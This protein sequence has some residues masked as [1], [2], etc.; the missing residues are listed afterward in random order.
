[1][2]NVLAVIF[3]VLVAITGASAQ[4]VTMNG[5]NE[6][7]VSFEAQSSDITVEQMNAID[8]LIDASGLEVVAIRGYANSLPN[9]V[10]LQ[11]NVAL[12]DDRA[13]SIADYLQPLNTI[14][15]T[16]EVVVSNKAS[17]R[18]TVIV[19]AQFKT[20][21]EPVSFEDNSPAAIII[22]DANGVVDTITAD[23]YVKFDV[24]GNEL[25]KGAFA[26]E[27]GFPSV[28]LP[29]EART[30]SATPIAT[31]AGVVEGPDHDLMLD[32]ICNCYCDE[33]DPKVLWDRYEALQDSAQFYTH[34]QNNTE[35]MMTA[36]WNLKRDQ[37]REKADAVKQCWHEAYRQH[38]KEE[39]C[40]KR[41]AKPTTRKRKRRTRKWRPANNW[42]NKLFPFNAC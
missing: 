10:T 38:K 18:K 21:E 13:W 23:E 41:N 33:Q 11:S 25:A 29:G 7:V 39:A 42:I 14:D 5:N 2:K 37:F 6:I 9:T 30:L 32:P 12:A 4:S 26:S 3:V 34:T 24:F 27:D 1:M 17:D 36:V 35:D 15:I 40:K 19:L 20:V 28:S 8:S 31:L 16:S 22:T